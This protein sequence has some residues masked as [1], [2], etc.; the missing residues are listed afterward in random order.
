MIELWEEVESSLWQGVPSFEVAADDDGKKVA[1][2]GG[3]FHGIR[4]GG[5]TATDAGTNIVKSE[6]DAMIKTVYTNYGQSSKGRVLVCSADAISDI[7]A[8]ISSTNGYSLNINAG[9]SVNGGYSVKTYK[10]SFTPDGGIPM[11]HSPIFDRAGIKGAVLL[12][13]DTIKLKEFIPFRIDKVTEINGN[14]QTREGA[15][16]EYGLSRVMFKKNAYLK[17]TGSTEPI[18]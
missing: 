5:G 13:L 4:S 3:V 14:Q 12:D 15:V 1:T 11:V 8:V 6:L 2:T 18:S 7:D 9:D 10:T 16:G 17:I